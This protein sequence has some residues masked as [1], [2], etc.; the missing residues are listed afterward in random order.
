MDKRKSRMLLVLLVLFVFQAGETA[1]RPS[2]VAAEKTGGEGEGAAPPECGKRT[3]IDEELPPDQRAES[4]HV[5]KAGEVELRYRATAATLPVEI[6]EGLECR[7]FFVSYELLNGPPASRPVTFAFNGG[8]GASSAYLHL[9]ALGPRHV[10]FD[11]DGGIPE[12]PPRLEENPHTWLRFTDLVFV[13]PVGTGYSRC[14]SGRENGKK[15]NG[16]PETGAWDVR[17]DLE[18]LAKFIRLYLTRNSRWLS[19]KFL[20]GESYGGF[21]VA[22]L[23]DLL[24]SDY[25]VAPRGIVL[26]SPAL[27]FRDLT[28]DEY[29]LLPWVITLPSYAATA[30]YHDRAAGKLPQSGDLREGLKEIEGFAIKELLPALADG[31]PSAMNGRIASYTGLPEPLVS[32]V[33][34]RVSPTLFSKELL[35]E[36][37]RLISIYDGSQTAVD[38]D[39]ASPWPPSTDPVLV[40]MNTLL[41]AALNS[42]V[43][44]RLGFKT[45]IPYKVLNKDVT[46]K[47]NW[48]SGLDAGQGFAGVAG[49]LKSSMSLNQYLKVF[50]AHGV[51]DL[52]TPYFGSVVI[53]RQ[54]SLDPAVS[55]NLRLRVYE[56][57]HMFYTHRQG[58]LDFFE[59][60]RTFFKNAGAAET[61]KNGP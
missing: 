24:T 44:E 14:V 27:E 10:L 18:S 58:R 54:M 9:A 52:V 32:R 45:D 33:N 47:W 28:R 8:P 7:I 53:T 40:H 43:R 56:G 4:E 55:A 22:A 49:N 29:S 11:P 20:V 23:S 2:A 6:R 5:L 3:L 31:D 35:R 61:G 60:A 1:V 12:P 36:E 25:G 17:E 26:V 42:H 21:R 15:E 51:Y 39:P 37:R 50:I 59:D 34:G 16:R 19:P 30:M 41:T 48:T 57:G 13:D 46:K 38:P